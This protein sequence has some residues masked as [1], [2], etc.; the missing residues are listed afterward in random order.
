MHLLT[1]SVE[2]TQYGPDLGCI[3]LFFLL[4]ISKNCLKFD[5]NAYTCHGGSTVA[6]NRQGS[7][8]KSTCLQV[9]VETKGRN[10]PIAGSRD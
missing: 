2:I 9:L 10:G 1:I 5:L 3:F 4:N 8:V 7:L 6:H